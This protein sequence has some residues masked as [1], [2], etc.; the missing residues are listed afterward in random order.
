MDDSKYSIF[1]SVFCLYID[2]FFI[3]CYKIWN[4]KI[5]LHYMMKKNFFCFY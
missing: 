2:C 5:F 4:E 3:F 1:L